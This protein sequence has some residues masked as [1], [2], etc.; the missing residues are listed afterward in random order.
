MLTSL[1]NAWM[2]FC[3][4]VFWFAS[5]SQTIVHACSVLSD[6]LRPHGPYVAR[7]T[8]LFMRFSRQEYWTGLPFP[9]AGDLPNPGIEAASLASPALAGR[10]LTAA[11]PGKPV[12]DYRG[13]S[14]PHT[15]PR[16][17]PKPSCQSFLEDFASAPESHAVVAFPC[18][19]KGWVSLCSH[20][21]P[22][23]LLA[24]YPEG[25][26]SWAAQGTSLSHNSHRSSHHHP[27]ISQLDVKLLFTHFLLLVLISYPLHPS[28]F[29]PTVWSLP[30]VF[31]PPQGSP[32]LPQ[33]HSHLRTS[34]LMSH[35]NWRHWLKSLPLL[36]TIHSKGSSGPGS[37]GDRGAIGL[38]RQ[39]ATK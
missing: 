6:S 34:P 20:P 3:F 38:W 26:I 27:T 37:E 35:L 28:K 25:V 30:W 8:T 29:C 11:L 31:L 9:I 18:R 4:L 13:V 7:Q 5:L 36:L 16:S 10:F 23:C 39:T 17:A 21:S 22:K 15:T 2:L 32:Q 33:L 24:D 12:T 19:Q 1:V 14:N